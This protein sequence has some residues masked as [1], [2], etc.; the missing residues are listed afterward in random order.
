MLYNNKIGGNRIGILGAALPGTC[1]PRFWRKIASLHHTQ[2]R[3]SLEERY[4]KGKPL[5]NFTGTCTG[6]LEV[7]PLLFQFF[8]L[9]SRMN[10]SSNL[11]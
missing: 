4:F 8:S 11:R 6:L 2:C 3:F 10:R 7:H 5:Y 1:A 9:Y